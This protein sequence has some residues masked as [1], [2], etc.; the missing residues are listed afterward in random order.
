MLISFVDTLR[1]VGNIFHMSCTFERMH[2]KI[3]ACAEMRIVPLNG[4]TRFHLP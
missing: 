1:E 2:R 3:Y 4:E